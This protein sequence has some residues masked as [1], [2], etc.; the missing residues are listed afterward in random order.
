MNF[1][2]PNHPPAAVDLLTP[3]VNVADQTFAKIDGQWCAQTQAGTWRPVRWLH[4]A[5]LA[6]QLLDHLT[7]NLTPETEIERLTQGGEWERVIVSCEPTVLVRKSA[8][9]KS[10]PVTINNTRGITT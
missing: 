3:T 8:R 7:T 4:G 5:A 9:S 10:F 6:D 2:V 1:G